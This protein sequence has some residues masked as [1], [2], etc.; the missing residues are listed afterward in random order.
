LAA[1]GPPR[2]TIITATYN[3]PE[4]LRLAIASALEQR[5]REFEQWVIGDACAD[6]TAAVIAEFD[7]PRLRYHNLPANSGNQAVPNNVGAELAAGELLAYLNHDDLW[8]P[9]H[10]EL[11]VETL[12][13]SGA[14]LVYALTSVVGPHGVVRCGGQ[15]FDPADQPWLPLCPPS[16]WLVRREAMAAI[17][18]WRDGSQLDGPVDLDVLQRLL[19]AGCQIA[20]ARRITALHF[21]SNL[22]PNAYRD[23]G[24]V[25]QQRYSAAL[26]DEPV[27]LERDLLCAVA[28]AF[29]GHRCAALNG[30][31]VL[32]RAAVL[33]Y[34]TVEQLGGPARWPF[35]VLR[36]WAYQRRRRA[37]YRRRGTPIDRSRERP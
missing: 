29:A 21:N 25:A 4:T 35:P 33:V 14:D 15:P 24:A 8:L 10:L 19:A 2:V 22:F 9:W 37:K 20:S 36:R 23:G 30:P 13:R 3:R 1:H 17:G 5:F 12:D 26:R 11:L 31:G 32:R 18:G 28:E 27:A 7:D 6:A 16:S 34:R